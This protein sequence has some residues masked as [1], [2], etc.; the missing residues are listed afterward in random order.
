MPRKRLEPGQDNI[1]STRPHKGTDAR[2]RTVWTMQWYINLNGQVSKRSTRRIGGTANDCR[3][4]ARAHADE[5]RQQARM[6]GQ[7]GWTALSRMDEFMERVCLPELLENDY[8]KPLRDSTIERL[9]QR[10]KLFLKEVRGMRI[11]DLTAPSTLSRI[12][13]RIAVA[14]GNP[15]AEQVAT[16]TRKYVFD[17]A[18]MMQII[19]YNPLRNAKIEV[20][21]NKTKVQPHR[22]QNKP[23]GGVAMGRD[24]HVRVI[25]YLLALD[26]TTPAVRGWTAEDMTRKRA[27]LIDIT[28]VQATC[29]LRIGEARN[30]RRRDVSERDGMLILSITEENSKT[31]RGRDIPVLNRRV[32]RRLRD[33]LANLP[34]DPD[35]FVFPGAGPN[36]PW[37]H[38]AC[39]RAMRAFY[40]ELADALDI[41]L[42]RTHSTHL[43][44]TTLNSEW[45]E[46][47]VSPERRA[48]Y[49]GHTVAINRSSY[50]DFVDFEELKGLVTTPDED[51]AADGGLD[52]SW[53]YDAADIFYSVFGTNPPKGAA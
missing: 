45:V 46:A 36:E 53:G 47:G 50:T 38:T 21:V 43:W 17:V 9:Q 41:D 44:R 19:Q 35:Q 6:P 52:G 3:Q 34:D 24:D 33:R 10:L 28:L 40:N 13:K 49:F 4:Q 32:E 7:G 26:P 14:H 30:L 39:A 29:G 16:A 25:D 8:A 22:G 12:F 2:G 11:C 20:T 37:S 18:V 27:S 31:K 5:L 15:T 48:A 51:A 1:A 23:K 42:L